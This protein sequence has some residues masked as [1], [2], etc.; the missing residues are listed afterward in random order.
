MLLV[1]GGDTVT[2]ELCEVNDGNF[3]CV[4]SFTLPTNY[5]YPLF[6]VLTDD[7]EDC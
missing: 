7:P 5:E 3:T 2:T 1:A 6:S 4:S